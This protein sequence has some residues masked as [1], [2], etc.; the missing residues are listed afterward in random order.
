M[1]QEMPLQDV[2]L[3]MLV[4]DPDYGLFQVGTFYSSRHAHSETVDSACSH[5]P[6]ENLYIDNNYWLAR[7]LCIFVLVYV[8]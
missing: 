8:P 5:T 7:H 4:E 1:A 6:A 2:V 3:V